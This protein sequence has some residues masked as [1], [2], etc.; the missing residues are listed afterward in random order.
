MKLL[1]DLS[2]HIFDALLPLFKGVNP[3]L[4]LFVEGRKNIFKTLE[5]SDL[6]QKKTIWVHAASLGEYE[7]AVPV[8][9]EIRHRLSD[10]FIVLTFFSP[11][12]YENKKM[13]PLADLITYLPLDTPKNAERFMQIVNPDLS[14]F[15]KYDIWPNYLQQLK[16]L[17]GKTYLVSGAFKKTQLYFK[18]YG[19]FMRKAL[20]AFDYIFLQNQASQQLLHSIDITETIVS[21]DTRFDRV[22]HQI[23]QD[24]TLSF[25]EDFV[26]DQLC[27]VC[28]S[29]WP[30]DEKIL[31]DFINSPIVQ[32]NRIKIVIAPHQINDKHINQLEEKLAVSSFRYSNLNGQTPQQVNVLII[33]AIG[34]LTRAY[35]YAD[36]AYVG[37][38][39]GDTGLHNILEPATFGIPIVIGQHF[40]DFPEA[41][42]LRQLAGLYSVASAK[43]LQ[44]I[45]IKLIMDEKFR[46]QTGMICGHYI[47]SN[48]GATRIIMEH[49]MNQTETA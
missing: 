42:K 11:S 23:E 7:Q 3:K 5:N 49:V 47:N 31:I 24:N 28:G 36:I 33:D 40:D 12:G 14:F 18:W 30:E 29:T 1:Y 19:G 45:M 32:E 38:A 20:N 2:I 16:K 35:S 15:I 4:R 22:A 25:I 27:I 41:K 8:L 6:T 17:K 13:S 39:M 46:R 9:Q 48:T 26:K 37:G 21:G 10:H 44:D 43:E 34:F